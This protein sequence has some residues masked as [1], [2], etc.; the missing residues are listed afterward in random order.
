VSEGL[1]T[2]ENRPELSDLRAGRIRRKTN[3]R[4]LMVGD[5]LVF[6]VA[7]HCAT[8]TGVYRDARARLVM[9][10]GGTLHRK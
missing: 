9:T 6:V 8:I 5:E 4:G 2:F 3:F 1:R 10:R 7:D